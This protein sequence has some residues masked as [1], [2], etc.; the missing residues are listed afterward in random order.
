MFY[1]HGDILKK[2]E[3]D[4]VARTLVVPVGSLYSKRASG[5]AD[6]GQGHKAH[7]CLAELREQPLDLSHALM[8][9]LFHF[10]RAQGVRQTWRA[11]ECDG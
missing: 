11:R 10:G 6:I 1:G 3:H 7:F 2:L 5:S 8:L 4:P 9:L